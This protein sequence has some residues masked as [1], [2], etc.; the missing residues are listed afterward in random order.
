VFLRYI[1]CRYTTY[2]SHKLQLKHFNY[3][4]KLTTLYICKKSFFLVFSAT[5]LTIFQLY[6]GG[7]FYCWRKP[8]D[9]EKTTDLSQVTDKLYHIILYTTHWS[10]FG[11]LTTSVVICTGCLG[12][13]KSNYHFITPTTAL[14]RSQNLHFR[15]KKNYA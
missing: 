6:R 10:R 8:E 2:E 14:V 13:C 3:R 15:R 1:H 4:V 7:Q 12:S 9:P 5:F 11:E